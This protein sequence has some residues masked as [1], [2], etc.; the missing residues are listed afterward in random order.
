MAP[1]GN[2]GC[3]YTPAGGTAI[4]QTPDGHAELFCDRM[5][6]TFVRVVMS[7]QSAAR[8]VD[9]QERG[10]CSGETIPYGDGWSEGPFSCEVTEASVA[11]RNSIGNGFTLSRTQADVR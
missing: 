2:I 3:T 9:T 11:C 4:Y 7:E 8:I 5:E 6:P 10:C 1:S